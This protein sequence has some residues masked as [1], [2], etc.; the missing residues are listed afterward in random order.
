MDRYS[1]NI[2][3]D[4]IPM[5]IWTYIRSR[6]I[7]LHTM[8]QL[9]M[10]IYRHSSNSETLRSNHVTISYVDISTSDSETF[11]CVYMNKHLL[12]LSFLFRFVWNYCVLFR[13]W[14]RLPDF[15]PWNRFL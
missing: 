4:I 12:R 7:S 10:C 2:L 8:W 6:D 1:R 3:C 11:P 14:L 5:Y 13:H 9:F 15:F